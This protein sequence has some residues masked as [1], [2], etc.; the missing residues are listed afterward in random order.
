M[1]RKRDAI[2]WPSWEPF[3]PE[4]QAGSQ[5]YVSGHTGVAKLRVAGGQF[6]IV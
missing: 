2:V 6:F 3:Y 4:T 5:L 1:S